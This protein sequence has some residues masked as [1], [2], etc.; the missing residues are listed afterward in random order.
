MIEIF[1]CT[2]FIIIF[3]VPY[4]HFVLGRWSLIFLFVCPVPQATGLPMSATGM[5]LGAGGVPSGLS[6]ASGGLQL[7]A[8]GL[9]M[10]AG[11][12]SLAP[13]NQG[14]QLQLPGRGLGAVGVTQGVSSS[15]RC[16]PGWWGGRG[17]G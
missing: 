11:G 4:L 1:F 16:L 2:F 15:T 9:Q 8:G 10:I 13:S 17:R 14:G 6:L 3:R 7:S 5:P 12:L